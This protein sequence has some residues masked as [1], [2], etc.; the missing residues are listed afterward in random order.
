MTVPTPP[1]GFSG[2]P[3]AVEG[4]L[5]PRPRAR[6]RHPG[7]LARGVP[8]HGDRSRPPR[9]GQ[10][11][12]VA[13]GHALGAGRPGRRA[14]RRGV[15]AG[16]RRRGGRRP[17]RLPRPRPS[18]SRP[19]AAAAACAAPACP[20]P[21]VSSSTSPAMA[22]V[23]AVDDDEPDGRPSSPARSGPTSRPS[24]APAGSPSAT[25]PS[26]WTSR[27]SAAGW[28]AGAPG[29][30]PPATGRSRT[31]WS[32]STSCSPTV[33]AI[34]HGRRAADRGRA[35]PHPALR[36]LGGHARRS[37]PRRGCASTRSR[38]PRAA[39][40]TRSPRGT[41]GVDACRRILRRGATP[42]V[43]RL[44]DEIESQ[45]SHGTDGSVAI[46]LVLDE[47][48]EPAG[49]RHDGHRR[50]GVRRRRSGSTTSWSS[51]GSS[52]ATTS[53][54][55]RRSRRRASSSTRSR[56][57][58]PGA[59]LPDD[60]PPGHGR[61]DGGAPH[62]VAVRPPLAQLRRR[63]LPVLHLR[64]HATRR[65][66]SSRRTSRCGTRARAPCSAPAAT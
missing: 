28:P 61:A 16:R 23:T 65:T 33:G 39:P 17:S 29:S 4:R 49:R 66:R 43:L 54:R 46:L 22:G 53:P 52:T 59:R 18:R 62:A 10:P 5:E 15:P 27:P 64:R 2:A 21:A 42:A 45:R 56:S 6:R 11:G 30:T 40:R 63:R 8:R 14:G 36:R 55:S 48:D 26:R 35:R 12:L 50:R 13:A 60:L 9:R 24:S 38:R 7:G 25:G 57:P 20:A 51:S 44:Y 37:S 58:A 19:P 1:I 47:A 3:A 31:W 34:T 41:P 32:A